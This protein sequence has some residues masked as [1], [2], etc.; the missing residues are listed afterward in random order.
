MQLSWKSFNSAVLLTAVTAFLY[1]SSTAYTYGY[2]RVLDLDG[3]VLDRNFHQIIYHGMILNIRTVVLAPLILA[4]FVTI[5]SSFK[6]EISQFI[7]RNFSNG[8]KLVKIKKKFYLATKR[9]KKLVREHGRKIFTFWVAAFGVLTVFMGLVIF[10]RKGVNSAEELIAE[11]EKGDFNSVRLKGEPSDDSLAYLFCGAR[12][13][14]V[15][16]KE[17]NKIVYFAQ[18]EFAYFRDQKM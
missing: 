7:S 1:A 6:I 4:L 12:N 10:E 14:A 17:T 18:N 8:R 13:C 5:H 11:I 15:Y 9:K 2:F 16:D 3:N